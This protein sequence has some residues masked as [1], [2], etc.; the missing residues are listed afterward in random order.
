[1]AAI[2][3]NSLIP[4]LK[5]HQPGEQTLIRALMLFGAVAFGLWSFDSLLCMRLVPARL[6]VACLGLLSIACVY[7]YFLSRKIEAFTRDL[8]MQV[9]DRTRDLDQVNRDLERQVFLKNEVE[10]RLREREERH[11]S[12]SEATTS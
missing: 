10:R 11:Y 6:F 2:I 7:Q 12:L 1:M 5:K 3:Q 8:E 9:H 4:W